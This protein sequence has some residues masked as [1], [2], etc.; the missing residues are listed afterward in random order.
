VEEVSAAV[1]G[2]SGWLLPLS[3][4]LATA[5]VLDAAF[6]SARAGGEPVAVDVN[7]HLVS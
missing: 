7:P 5:A 1:G 2:G 4:S 6:A 3:E